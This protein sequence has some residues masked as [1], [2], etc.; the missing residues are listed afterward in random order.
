MRAEEEEG[1]GQVEVEE[2]EGS[3]QVE[4]AEGGGQVEV[5]EGGGG[6]VAEGWRPAGEAGVRGAPELGR[7]GVTGKNVGRW[8]GL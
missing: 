7:E 2:E 1:S 5:A 3:G 4:V 6:W 8:L